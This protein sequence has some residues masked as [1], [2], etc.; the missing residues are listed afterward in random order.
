MEFAGA[1]TPLSPQ[2]L[3]QAT[4]TV[5]AGAAE[6]WTVL[7]V[8]TSGFGF[9]PDRRPQI[10]FE[11]H[12]FHQQTS[13]RFDAVNPAISSPNSGGYSGGVKE[14]DRLAQAIALDRH[15][16]LGSASW[17]IGQ[18]LGINF[19]TTGAASV[20]DMVAAAVAS[21]DQQLAAMAGFVRST[22]LHKALA[23]H[24]WAAFA[25]GY[26]GPNFAK[27]NYD[28]L[29]NQHFQKF[30]AGPLPDI[31]VRQAQALLTFLG[32]DPNGV[33]GLIG[34]RTRDAVTQFRSANG[35][36]NSDEIDDELIAALSARLAPESASATSA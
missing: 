33:D 28:T 9:L 22:G 1:A 6:I 36:G 8:E 17:G 30:S 3:E 13:G 25:R 26:N 24:D 35:L 11:R 4:E 19:I 5:A 7:A 18:V 23:N 29:L 15:A 10:L 31:R 2:G 14:Y 34:K 16:A 27:N 20:E 21:E 32:L 12:I